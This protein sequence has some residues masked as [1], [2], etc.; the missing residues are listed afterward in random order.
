MTC[1]DCGKELTPS[2]L[3]EDCLANDRIAVCRSCCLTPWH[4]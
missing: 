2:T 3:C 1:E 4:E